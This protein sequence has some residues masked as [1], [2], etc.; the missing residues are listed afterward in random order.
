MVME[1]SKRPP[2]LLGLLGVKD[3]G[4][5]MRLAVNHANVV[6]WSLCRPNSQ[7][8][9]V[10]AKRAN[11]LERSV[12]VL[13]PSQLLATVS[14]VPHVELNLPTL[15]AMSAHCAELRTT[16]HIAPHIGSHHKASRPSPSLKS[17][18]CAEAILSNVSR[19]IGRFRFT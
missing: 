7:K 10:G 6:G 12:E 14:V 11:L 19:F 4:N 3:D 9:V 13:N 15:A 17:L 16:F 5:A 2:L 8:R 1:Q 18:G